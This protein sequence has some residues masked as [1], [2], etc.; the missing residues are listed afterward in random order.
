V[1]DLAIAG[2]AAFTKQVAVTLA[3]LSMTATEECRVFVLHDGYPDDV[4]ARLEAGVTDAVRIEW[5]YAPSTDTQAALLPAGWVE[6]TLYRLRLEALLPSEVERVIYLDSDVVV[7]D[8]LSPLWDAVAAS[9][10]TLA[11]Q[12]S[13]CPWICGPVGLPWKELDLAPDL[14]HF[15][16]GVLA[17][18]LDRWRGAQ[19]GTRAL[20]LMR[21][22]EFALVDQGALN[23][24]LAGEWTKLDPRWNLT[25]G[26]FDPHGTLAWFSEGVDVL[27]A[28]LANP[29]VVHFTRGSSP[30]RP[31]DRHCVHPLR[32][33]WFE[34]LD[35]T[36]WAGWRPQPPDRRIP[37]RVAR[38]LQRTARTLVHG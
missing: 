25:G 10:R 34:A 3:S 22:V 1:I 28:A 35:H 32:D 12:S 38:R 21:H 30:G 17:I 2:D 36:S 11:V 9:D 7:L 24:V 37:A 31:W 4:R 20:E 33:R 23:A 13:R 8:S 6:A 29:A 18:P 15:N 16:A 19:V 26:H 27:T 5:R 14:P